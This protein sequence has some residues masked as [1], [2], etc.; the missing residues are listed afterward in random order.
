MNGWRVA[1]TVLAVFR[2]TAL[3][4][5]D[6]V[7][8]PVRDRIIRFSYRR[9]GASGYLRERE[10]R[11]MMDP[12]EVAQDDPDPP[13]LAYLVTCWWCSSIYVSGLAVLLWWLVPDVWWPISAV[14][15]LSALTVL[16]HA[17]ED[18]LAP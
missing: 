16:I 5:F 8:M 14:L 1:A 11:D 18:R 17:L 7:S 9:S 2:L 13:A 15:A 4:V 3:V 10:E 6:R 12:T